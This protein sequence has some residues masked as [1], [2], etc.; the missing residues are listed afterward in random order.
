MA[1]RVNENDLAGDLLEGAAEIAA[2]MFGSP[3]KRRKVYALL[4][5]G[6]SDI[7]IFRMGSKIVARK[8]AIIAWFE[9]QEGVKAAA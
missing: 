6:R 9:K 8:S 5:S 3:K 4:E 7:P 1:M 2:F